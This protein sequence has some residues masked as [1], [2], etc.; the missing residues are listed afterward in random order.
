MS[1]LTLDVSYPQTFSTK[2]AEP[3]ASGDAGGDPEA[4]AA[5]DLM[6]CTDWVGGRRLR[7][8]VF[9]NCWS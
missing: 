7:V 6:A 4:E 1:M 8:N 2:S 9:A 3:L 5:P